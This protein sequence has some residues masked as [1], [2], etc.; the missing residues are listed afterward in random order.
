MSYGFGGTG[1]EETKEGGSG[2]GSGF[3]HE[4]D[5]N[6]GHGNNRRGDYSGENRE[7]FQK[8]TFGDKNHDFRR[9]NHQN[10]GGFGSGGGFGSN[11]QNDNDSFHGGQRG[12]FGRYTSDQGRHGGNRSQYSNNN[13]WY[14]FLCQNLRSISLLGEEEETDQE[15]DLTGIVANEI[16]TSLENIVEMMDLEE[17]VEILVAIVIAVISIIETDLN[18]TTAKVDGQIHQALAATSKALHIGVTG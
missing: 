4:T 17:I 5:T 16:I 2:F 1:F 11:R 9:D 13:N 10:Q 18:M 6:V 15:A 12:G 8:Y 14:L 3:K 7:R